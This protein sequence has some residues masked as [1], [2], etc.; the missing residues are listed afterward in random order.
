MKRTIVLALV[1]AV[2]AATAQTQHTVL[3]PKAERESCA[4][5]RARL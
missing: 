1:L 5:V 2:A 3:L 4:R